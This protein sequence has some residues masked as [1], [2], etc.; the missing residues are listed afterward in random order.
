M[1]LPGPGFHNSTIMYGRAEEKNQILFLAISIILIL[2]LVCIGAM[3]IMP[4]DAYYHF[5]GEHL[6]LSYFDHPPMIAYLLRL[7]TTIFGKHV[8]ALKLADSIVSFLTLLVFFRL[9]KCFLGMNRAWNAV[10][11]FFSTLMLTILSLISTP[12]VPL[13]LFWTISLLMLYHAIFLERKKYWIWSGIAMGLSFDSK[14][15][16]VA[17]LGGLTLFLIFSKKY[18]S[19]LFSRWFCL[20]VLLFL[21][22]ISPVI[23]WNVQN[24][25]ASFRFQSAGRMHS[26]NGIH[27]DLTD[28]AGLIGHQAAILIPV[29]FFSLFYFLF[30]FLKKSRWRFFIIS[31]KNLFLLSFFLPLFLGFILLSFIYWI[32]LNWIMPAY[33][34]GIIWVSGYISKKWIRY[35]VIFSAVIHIALAIELF[36]YPFRINSDDTWVGWPELAEQV[37][38]IKKSYPDAFIFSADD[39]KT[40][41]VLNFYVNE[42]VYSR[43]II[44]KNALQFDFIGSDLNALAGRS[45]IFINSVNGL[46]DEEKNDMQSEL[47]EYFDSISPL[48]PILVMKGGNPVRKFSVYLCRN[49]HPKK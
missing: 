7:F 23:I 37:K 12:D 24:H 46:T 44:G 8:F 38:S 6:A 40:S 13:L 32:K 41:A 43:N 17:L 2:R 45:A 31:Q 5:Y 28:F 14:Y 39:Y 18:R 21:V 19:L 9:A 36:W 48:Q 10:L 35:Q 3:G 25:F 30:K 1:I 33:V 16:G 42:M 49:Y 4:Q 47:Q 34:S 20:C 22:T 29:L 26:M 27:F 15:T 11:I